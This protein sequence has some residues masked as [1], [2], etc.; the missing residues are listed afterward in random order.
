MTFS[1]HARP[2]QLH[3]EPREMRGKLN[4]LRS[5]KN[6]FTGVLTFARPTGYV[7]LGQYV[8]VT[9]TRN[10]FDAAESIVCNRCGTLLWPD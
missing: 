4:D 10:E 9:V 2:N 8:S 6:A 5:G 3:K 7:A 1:G